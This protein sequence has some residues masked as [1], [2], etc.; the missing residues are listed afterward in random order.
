MKLREL[1]SLLQQHP[2]HLLRLVLPDGDSIP[3]H[4]HVT[5]VGYVTKK[6]V[7]CGGT[8]REVSSCVLQTWVADDEDHR[9]NAG[10]LGFILN[11]AEPILPQD[12]LEVEVEY[13]D[14]V[15]SQY[16][17]GDA[18]VAGEHLTFA[19][20]NKHT[21]CLAKEACGLESAAREGKSGCC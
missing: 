11:L 13:E 1:K 6:F 12:D 7:D 18:A 3:A 16:P 14:C 17:I 10:K 8:F 20:T 4:F 2:D 9:L 15:I 21:D 5:E 19:L